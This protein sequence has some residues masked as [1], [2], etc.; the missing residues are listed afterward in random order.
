MSTHQKN[1]LI[2]GMLVF[3]GILFV[4]ALLASFDEI[5]RRLS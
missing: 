4:F 5:V 1:E 3:Y 2:K